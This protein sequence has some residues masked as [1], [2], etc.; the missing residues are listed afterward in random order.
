MQTK[1]H[2]VICKKLFIVTKNFVKTKKWFKNA[3]PVIEIHNV[4]SEH[5]KKL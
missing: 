1:T 4:E 5:K 2:D 3:N